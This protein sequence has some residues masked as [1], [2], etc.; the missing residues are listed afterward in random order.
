MAVYP[1]GYDSNSFVSDPGSR[2]ESEFQGDV[3]RDGSI[4]LIEVGKVD[5]WEMH[6]A[7][8][9]QC[10]VNKIVERF[11]AGDI[12]ALNRVQG[13]YIDLT[14]MPNDL[15]GMYDFSQALENAFYAMP[16]EKRKLF[17]NDFKVWLSAAGSSEWFAS[18][19][20]KVADPA[21]ESSEVKSD[22]QE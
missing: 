13:S 21:T 18:M 16:E 12:T 15:R 7:G 2:Y 9:D 11:Q 8:A 6:N 20:E 10:D 4:E 19:T 5:L 14:G 1:K 22:V 17:D 3:K